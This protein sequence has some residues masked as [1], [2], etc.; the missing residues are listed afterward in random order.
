MTA[1]STLIHRAEAAA[2]AAVPGI[3]ADQVG[4][5]PASVAPAAPADQVGAAVEDSE[6]ARIRGA[7]PLVVA[8]VEAVMQAAAAA[9]VVDLVEAAVVAD[10]AARAPVELVAAVGTAAPA[11]LAV[12]RTVK[13]SARAGG[14]EKR[15]ALR[16]AFY[17]IYMS[18]L[19]RL[20]R[21][22]VTFTAIR[23]QHHRSQ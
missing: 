6:A 11:T 20:R 8:L 23:P 9:V 17:F 3:R 1:T 18:E 14:A 10:S 19:A 12:Y 16:P 15:N 4:G 5:V 2:V 21:I 13:S 7:A 22:A